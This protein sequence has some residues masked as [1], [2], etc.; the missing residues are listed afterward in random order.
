MRPK[1]LKILLHPF[2]DELREKDT[3]LPDG[4]PLPQELLVFSK[5][6]IKLDKET[7]EKLIPKWVVKK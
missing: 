6:E 5:E 4:R 7:V 2:F 1:P 3:V